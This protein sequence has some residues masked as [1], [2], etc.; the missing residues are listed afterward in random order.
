MNYT[1]VFVEDDDD[2]ADDLASSSEEKLDIL[3]PIHVTGSLVQDG[4]NLIIEARDWKMRPC[5]FWILRCGIRCTHLSAHQLSIAT[6]SSPEKRPMRDSWNI[7][8]ISLNPFRF[9]RCNFGT[10]CNDIG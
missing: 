1:M 7:S 8:S 2:I 4:E 6:V 9:P 10:E 5:S 3:I